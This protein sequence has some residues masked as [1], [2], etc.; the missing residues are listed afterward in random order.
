MAEMLPGLAVQPPDMFGKLS[1]LQNI[2]SVGLANQQEQMNLA[3]R[4]RVGQ[5][6]SSGKDL[7]GNSILDEQ[8]EPD[9]S[10]VIPAI[11]K[12]APTTGQP[13]IQAVIKTHSDKVGLS[14]SVAD[15]SSKQREALSGV[16]GSFIGN[17]QASS[18]DI[19]SALD[20]YLRDNPSSAGA[21]HYASNL[22][23]HVDNIKDPKQKDT[24]LQHL[25]SSLMSP[26]QLAGYQ[27]PAVSTVQGPT[28]AQPVNLNPR[29]PGGVGPAG[30][31]IKQGIAPGAHILTDQTGAQFVLD[32]QTN[33]LKPVGTGRGAASAGT[34]SAQ[35]FKQ[36]TYAG[37]AGDIEHAQT[38]VRQVRTAGDS[39]PLNRNINQQILALSKDTTTGPGTARWQHTL[40]AV[41]LGSIGDNY[42]ELGKYLEKNAL[43]AMAAMGGPASDARLSAAVA[44]N[45]STDFNPGALQAVTK[46]NDATNTAL[47]KYRQGIDNAIGTRNPD[48]N[49]Y[50]EFR[51]DWAKNFDVNVFRYEN[52]VRDHDEAEI[53]KIEKEQGKEGMTDL[54]KKR[55]NLESL[56][57]N[58]EPAK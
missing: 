51:A 33:Q 15:L 17:P 9:P 27:Q 41:G 20:A 40:A 1:Q 46:F 28:G 53:T 45:G 11:S 6:M 52:A 58:G 43:N 57:K 50:P 30:A 54:L 8:G 24:A 2:R 36:P 32:P 4:Q 10:K 35:T 31:P 12:A 29:A 18:K 3:E 7:D 47:I 48:Y 44:A 34:A 23:D 49:K 39:A 16:V 19:N 26:S 38:E 56:S 22:I 37:Q 14:S 55:R 5:I 42:Q 21:V 13:Y 25:Q